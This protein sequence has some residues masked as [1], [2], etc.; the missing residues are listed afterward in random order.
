MA[1]W[2]NTND[3]AIHAARKLS[4]LHG[5]K[6]KAYQ[7]QVTDA[8]KVE[9]TIGEVVKDFGKLD[10]FV[11]NAGA[12]NSKPLLEMELEEYYHLRSVNCECYSL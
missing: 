3:S 8:K 12:A 7:V 1:L 4:E 6:A 9:Q 10:I 11:A 5:V 2:Y